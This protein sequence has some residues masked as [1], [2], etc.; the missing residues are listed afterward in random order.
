MT[1]SKT[2]HDR[3]DQGQLPGLAAARPVRAL[4]Q[5]NLMTKASTTQ[6]PLCEQP[7]PVP[8]VS[9]GEGGRSALPPAASPPTGS[10]ASLPV[11]GP[12][13][14]IVKPSSK[15]AAD[16]TTTSENVRHDQANDHQRERVR[17]D[18]RRDS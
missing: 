17:R 11:R 2:G 18:P 6:Q 5:L 15:T 10:P 7:L 12:F 14:V 1:T 16:E 3:S 8:L 9:D 13:A 4:V